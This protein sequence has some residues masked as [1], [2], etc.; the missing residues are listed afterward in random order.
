MTTVAPAVS[1]WTASAI[2]VWQIGGPYAGAQLRMHPV[3]DWVY[4]A[5]RYLSPSDLKKFDVALFFGMRRGDSPYH[6]DYPIS[7]DVWISEDG[8]RLLTAGGSTFHASAGRDTDMTYAGS[9]P[10]GVRVHCAGH[11][12]ETNEW[13]ALVSDA[14]DYEATARRLAFYTGD[15]FNE[16]G[17][18]DLT[19]VP[20]PDGIAATS[21]SHVFQSEDG[22]TVVIV[23]RTDE[24]LHR[25]AVQIS[26]R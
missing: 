23:L 11:S 10:T 17:V 20:V 24:L 22:D 19:G 1:L 13:A 5:D 4:T 7:G 3:E 2:S 14:R 16:V 18:V 8:D 26:E 21:G 15:F 9:V 6:G 12:T 25:Y